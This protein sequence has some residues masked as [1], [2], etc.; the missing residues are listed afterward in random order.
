MRRYTLIL[1]SVLA[2]TLVGCKDQASVVNENLTR[3]ADNFSILRRIILTNTRDGSYLMSIEGYCS[4][5]FS[6]P[7]R[8]TCATPGGYKR[9]YMDRSLS[10]VIFA[11]Q[12]EPRNVSRDFYQVTFRPQTIIPDVRLR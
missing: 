12:L 5:E 4:L 7:F 10:T 2:L 6:Q 3:E 1:L 8:I 9:H 11:E